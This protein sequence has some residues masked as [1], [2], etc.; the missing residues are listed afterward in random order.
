MNLPSPNL[1]RCHKQWAGKK[2]PL[3]C[4]G[5]LVKLIEKEEQLEGGKWRGRKCLTEKS[6]EK[7]QENHVQV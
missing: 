2:Y 7:T 3:S 4:S 1:N 5:N 6:K